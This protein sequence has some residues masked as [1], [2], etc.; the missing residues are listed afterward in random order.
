MKEYTIIK[1][2][3]VAEVVYTTHAVSKTFYK[4]DDG[5]LFDTLQE[6]EDYELFSNLSD[7]KQLIPQIIINR[8]YFMGL[9][10]IERCPLNDTLYFCRNQEEIIRIGNFL[11]RKLHYNTHDNQYIKFARNYNTF[12]KGWYYFNTC[13]CGDAPDELEYTNIT[14]VIS[15]HIQL[16]EEYHLT[17]DPIGRK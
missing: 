14:Q 3:P 6:C 8:S 11:L 7:F 9:A 1:N 17:T 16:N 12:T 10:D 2:E 13:D 5:Q 4:A 15:N